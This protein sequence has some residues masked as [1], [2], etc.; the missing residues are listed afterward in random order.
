MCKWI[1]VWLSGLKM[2]P[3]LAFEAYWRVKN[4]GVWQKKES[5]ATKYMLV[6]VV[7]SLLSR[8]SYLYLSLENPR[9]LKSLTVS[10]RVKHSSHISPLMDPKK[11][12]NASIC[13]CFMCF[14][15]SL[16]ASGGLCSDSQNGEVEVIQQ[17]PPSGILPRAHPVGAGALE[18]AAR[19][20]QTMAFCCKQSQGSLPGAL[21]LFLTL[22]L[23]PS[24]R[25]RPGSS[26]P[27]IILDCQTNVR[28]CTTSLFVAFA[29]VHSDYEPGST[30]DKFKFVENSK[31]RW[32][33]K[34]TV[35][36]E[37]IV[38]TQ[39]PEQL[40]DCTAQNIMSL[41]LFIGWWTT[42]A[43]ALSRGHNTSSA[44]TFN[45]DLFSWSTQ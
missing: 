44:L 26:L 13:F 29:F 18:P 27:T 9:H 15:E 30:T 24:T 35:S 34:L 6:P 32:K 1:S 20:H 19:P 25:L 39:S 7:Y 33:A 4:A 38:K 23:S 8:C 41:C 5:T 14:S 11:I 3:M 42:A 31:A 40:F 28:Q 21:S 37:R 45:V 2:S 10:Q 12:K 36:L 17:W 22:P 43:D 16:E